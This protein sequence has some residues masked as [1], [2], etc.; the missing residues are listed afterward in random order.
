MLEVIFSADFFAAFMRV[1]TPLLLAALGVMISERAGLLNIGMEGMML[2]GAFSGMLISALAGSALIGLLGAIA[3]GMAIGLL[4]AW[5]INGLKA[6]FIIA[7]IAI[8]VAAASA[9]TLGLYM[10]TGDRGMSGALK[11]FVLPNVD[12]FGIPL[13]SGHHVLTWAALA[14]VPLLHLLLTKTVFGLRLRAVGMDAHSAQIAGVAVARTQAVALMMSGGL[15]AMAGAYL[16][17]GYVSWFAEGMTAGRGF[18]AVAIAVMGFGSAIATLITAIIIGL[19]EAL[20]L[21]LQTLGLPSELLQ[22]IPYIVPVIVLTL[23]SS[24]RKKRRAC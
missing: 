14:L 4:M 20:S 13:L 18:I 1:L 5:V 11:S 23:W 6:H 2:S 24:R 17:M 3:T 15:G 12:V 9:T 7:G 8:N 10:A 16:S 19:A 22:A 21:R